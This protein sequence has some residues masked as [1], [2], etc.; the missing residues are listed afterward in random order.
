[1]IWNH[2]IDARAIEIPEHANCQFVRS[3]EK[4]FHEKEKL[5]IDPIANL[6]KICDAVRKAHWMTERVNN[7]S[8]LKAE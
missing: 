4:N 3:R 2:R 5:P 7:F 8:I 1:M 6:R